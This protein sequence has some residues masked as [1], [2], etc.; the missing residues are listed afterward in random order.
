MKNLIVNITDKTFHQ[1]GL[2]NEFASVRDIE[3][4]WPYV[5]FLG[6]ES[7]GG[8]YKLSNNIANGTI[9]LRL[10]KVFENS[11]TIFR[12]LDE[13][14]KTGGLFVFLSDGKDIKELTPLFFHDYVIHSLITRG[15]C[16]SSHLLYLMYG[17]KEE[18]KR[19][20]ETR[21]QQKIKNDCYYFTEL[22]A[23]IQ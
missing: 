13:V 5:S 11:F 9:S 3:D 2:S 7:I 21:M 16:G 8:L 6:H 4:E 17:E 23:S 20:I 12:L 18:N 10:E 1:F 14:I 15:I 22:E 19:L